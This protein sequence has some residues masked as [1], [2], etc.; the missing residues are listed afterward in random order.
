M[1]AQ[2]CRQ[3]RDLLGHGGNV[4]ASDCEVEDQR[5]C[6]HLVAAPADRGL[7]TLRHRHVDP[8]LGDS[9]APVT[10]PPPG[11]VTS[12]SSSGWPSVSPPSRIRVWPVMYDD[13]AD[14]RNATALAT[15]PGSPKRPR[16]SFLRYSGPST[17]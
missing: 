13:S 14:A 9:P 15:S 11:S 10:A 8:S 3:R 12:I 2:A 17:G 5:G 4:G 6:L 16:G 1:R 7:V